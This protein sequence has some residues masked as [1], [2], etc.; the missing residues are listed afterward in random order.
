[1]ER[2][3]PHLLQNPERVFHELWVFSKVFVIEN[4][5][6]N[7]GSILHGYNAMGVFLNLI[8]TLL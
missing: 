1:M 2:S 5:L 4:V 3:A 7:M 6:I 8:K